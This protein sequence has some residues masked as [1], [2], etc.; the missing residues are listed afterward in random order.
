MQSPPGKQTGSD[1]LHNKMA[2][3]QEGVYVHLNPIALRKAKIVHNYILR[4]I[5]LN[6][7]ASVSFSFFLFFCM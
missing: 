5:Q 3:K 7:T 1:I 6:Q 4:A 2:E